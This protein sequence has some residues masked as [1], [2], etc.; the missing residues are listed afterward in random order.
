MATYNFT[1]RAID[2]SG[3]FSD[4]NFAMTV[5]NTQ[6][7]RFIISTYNG[8]L[9]STDGTTWNLDQN[10]Y[11]EQVRWEN[12]QWIGYSSNA[13]AYTGTIRTSVDGLNWKSIT[14]TVPF[15]A[16]I[17][18]TEGFSNLLFQGWN[19]IKYRKGA[20]RGFAIVYA[21]LNSTGVVWYLYEEY[22][23]PDLVNWTP[24][25]QVTA[26]VGTSVNLGNGVVD[27]DYDPA[28]DTTVALFSNYQQGGCFG[29][30]RVGTGAWGNI[31]I[32]GTSLGGTVPLESSRTGFTSSTRTGKVFFQNGVWIIS[33]GAI[34]VWTST[35]GN[36]FITRDL[37]IS[38]AGIGNVIYSNG[39]LLAYP[40]NSTGLTNPLL[41][42]TNAGHTWTTRPITSTQKLLST[43]TSNQMNRQN[44][45][46]YGGTIIAIS[47]AEANI[48][49]S[50]DDGLNWSL[51]NVGGTPI[52]IASRE[53]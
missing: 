18:S 17:T 9:R 38:S 16:A 15:R 41:Q 49:V 48:V 21:T 35:D 25:G 12:N 33:I 6:V 46:S 27:F 39:R 53:S 32:T 7:D 5:N 43:F 3:A 4:R 20:W 30:R 34:L 8:F 11:S 37:S 44:I 10:I 36:N 45:A 26:R 19:S 24:V 31:Y 13:Y 2:N 29:Y 51:I 42:S 23:S 47:P 28:T 14:P 22:S 40:M 52:S 1:V 50:K